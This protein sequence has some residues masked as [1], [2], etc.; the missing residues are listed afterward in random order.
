MAP[1][2]KRDVRTLALRRTH[3]FAAEM[4][5]SLCGSGGTVAA[6]GVQVVH[7][8]CACAVSSAPPFAAYWRALASSTRATHCV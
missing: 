8:V 6:K 5:V 1:P 4:Q 3:M 7:T 2:T